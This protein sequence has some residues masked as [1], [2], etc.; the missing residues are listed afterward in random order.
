MGVQIVAEAGTGLEVLKLVAEHKPD[1][2]LM[3]IAMPELNGLE[4]TARLTER[5]PAARV[6]IISM[7][8]NIEYARRAMQAGAA[9][10][11]LKNAK[12][13]EL[14]AALTAVAHGEVYL[15]PAVAK[16]VADD[17]AGRGQGAGAARV[18]LSPRQLEI[19]QLIAKGYTRRQISDKLAISVKTFDTY[20]SQLMR[21]L[22]LH[23]TAGLVRFA[24]QSGLAAPDE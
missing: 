24:L 23:D 15:S 21:Q 11:L 14:E 2:V 10:Y 20:R 18:R 19:L 8:A 17:Y 9:G 5:F 7:H 12:A 13:A 4:A 6:V 3:D 1:L 22:D 16:F